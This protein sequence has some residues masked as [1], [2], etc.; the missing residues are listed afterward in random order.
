MSHEI[1]QFLLAAATTSIQAFAILYLAY[2]PSTHRAFRWW[3]AAFVITLLRTLILPFELTYPNHLEGIGIWLIFVA[4]LVG[5][6]AARMLLDQP[7]AKSWLVLGGGLA[8]FWA[9]F[10]QFVLGTIFWMQLPLA[11]LGGSVMIA[12]G[13]VFLLNRPPLKMNG[14]IIACIS[15]SLMGIHFMTYPWSGMWPWLEPVGYL[16]ATV[17]SMFIAFAIVIVAGR[18]EAASSAALTERLSLS[19]RA[20]REILDNLP[21]G[22]YR[23]SLDGHILRAN[24][25]LARL[26]GYES[27]H[28]YLAA[29]SSLD[30]TDIYVIPGRR[31][32]FRRLALSVPLVQD[33]ESQIYRHRTGEIIWVSESGRAVRN[34]Q[35]ELLYFEGTMR[36][37]TQD[38]LNEEAKLLGE[39]RLASIM[40][41]APFGIFMKTP[42]GVYLAAN[43]AAEAWRKAQD[44]VGKR[45]ADFMNTLDAARIANEDMKVLASGQ[46]LYSEQ[47]SRDAA[48]PTWSMVVRFPV[49]GPS[50]NMIAIGGFE[51]DVSAQKLAELELIAARDQATSANNAKSAFLANMSH[52]LRTPLNAII[53]FAEVLNREI[54]GSLNERQKS[55]LQDIHQAGAHLLEVIN[56]ILDMS[57]IE[58]GKLEIVPEKIDPLEVIQS[59]MHIIRGKMNNQGQ[60][61]ELECHGPQPYLMVD[62]RAF[63]QIL[64]NFLSNAAKFTPAGGKIKVFAEIM[65]QGEYQILVAD[66]GIGIAPDKIQLVLEPFRQAD[67][68]IAKKYEGSGLGLPISKRLIELHGGQ[69]LIQ[70]T[71]GKGTIVGM[72]LPKE[73]VVLPT[74]E[75][76]KE[77]LSTAIE[78]STSAAAL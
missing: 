26:N 75:N 43:R 77:E 12:S 5:Y 19:E 30:M 48:H 49:R 64:L 63:K 2:C 29:I 54:F 16:A 55:Y 58:A 31:A 23:S 14:H 65:P 50:G 53:G 57:R 27:V 3:G 68:A 71:L 66:T 17:L 36:D 22:V 51:I 73:R 70:S 59:S 76:A 7:V 25:A 33:F 4:T 62:P 37:I 13:L 24:Q 10:A 21:D 44:I 67:P 72:M 1:I 15:L 6:L 47:A 34:E 9:L 69:L 28:A 56:D 32:E 45:D 11:L 61:L 40:E 78:A 74:A 18:R 8:L 60:H 46:P 39:A 35:G 42:D 38:K 20:Y 52:E 41:H